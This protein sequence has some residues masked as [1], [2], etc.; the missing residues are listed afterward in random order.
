V[1]PSL[2][3]FVVHLDDCRVCG[4]SLF[5]RWTARPTH[6]VACGTPTTWTL[7]S[8]TRLR[9]ASLSHYVYDDRCNTCG[10]S[11]IG[12]IQELPDRCPYCGR[13]SE[14][15]SRPG[16]LEQHLLMRHFD[17]ISTRSQRLLVLRWRRP[18]LTLADIGARL[19]GLSVER[20]RQV[21]DAAIRK[22]RHAA[23]D[24]LNPD[25]DIRPARA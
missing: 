13:S 6:C 17:R 16:P 7:S 2:P 24:G 18:E 9:V 12:R 10:R 11:V 4:R 5:G 25:D 1:V 15:W 20:V 3:T 8:Y 19:D 21:E 23:Y 14:R 22:L